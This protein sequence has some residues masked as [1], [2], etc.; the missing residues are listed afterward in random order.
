[1]PLFITKDAV[2][3]RLTAQLGLTGGLYNLP[4]LADLVVPVLD[5]R[6]L[7]IETVLKFGTYDISAA[8]KTVYTVPKGKRALVV[9]FYKAA[10][11]GA[12]KLDIVGEGVAFSLMVGT[13]AE[14]VNLTPRIRID[15]AWTV[16]LRAANVADAAIYAGVVV[17]EEDAF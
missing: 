16:V 1:M 2:Y 11:V 5:I 6:P 7:L 9:Y 10:T 14:T 12:T 13:T 17:E 3:R 4:G 15:T 8:D